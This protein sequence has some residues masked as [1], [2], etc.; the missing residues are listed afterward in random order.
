MKMFII[1]VECTNVVM[2]PFNEIP[3]PHHGRVM[4]TVYIYMMG[5]SMDSNIP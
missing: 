2:F 3:F 4:L 5:F 1:N